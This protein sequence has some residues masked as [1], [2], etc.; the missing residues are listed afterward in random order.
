M[1]SCSER[2]DA[3]VE[4]PDTDLM[5]MKALVFIQNN[6]DNDIDVDALSK[7]VNYSR[8]YFSR[9]FSRKTGLSIPQYINKMRVEKA[10]EL[11]KKTDLTVLEVSKTVG[12]EDQFYF[13]KVF[14]QHEGISPFLFRNNNQQRWNTIAVL[15]M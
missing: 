12:F 2:L 7:Y 8:S 10:K 4:W 11:L 9:M 5:I 6:I 3:I 1:I 15:G 14:K 13:S